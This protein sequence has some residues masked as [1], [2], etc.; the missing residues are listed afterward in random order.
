[1]QDVLPSTC[2]SLPRRAKLFLNELVGFARYYAVRNGWQHA[3]E[4]TVLIPQWLIADTLGVHVDTVR[5][6]RKN[7]AVRNVISSTKHYT[8][9]HYHRLIDGVMFAINL[10]P[11]ETTRPRVRFEP[12]DKPRDLDADAAAGRIRASWSS[13]GKSLFDTLRAWFFPVDT[14][15]ASKSPVDDE[16]K[17]AAPVDNPLSVVYAA[18]SRTGRAPDVSGHVERAARAITRVLSDS[19]NYLPAWYKVIWT[20]RRKPQRD[21]HLFV[22]T[23]QNLVYAHRYENLHKPG[24]ALLRECRTAGWLP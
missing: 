8:D 24:P 12:D 16:C 3:S 10:Y 2:D 1:M 11:D 6:W 23:L 14:P 19:D 9:G 22:S 20:L 18:C 13:E 17:I 7:P 15:Q 21:W 4:I 5:R